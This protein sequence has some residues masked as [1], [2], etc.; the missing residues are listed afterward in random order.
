MYGKSSASRGLGKNGTQQWVARHA[1]LD[2][3]IF[4]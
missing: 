3:E 2:S 4:A 1:N